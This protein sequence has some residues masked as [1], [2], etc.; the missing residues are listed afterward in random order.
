[1]AVKGKSKSKLSAAQDDGA[2]K[3]VAQKM[4]DSAQQ[5]WLAGLGAF[6]KAQDE[7]SK[8]FDNLVSEGNALEKATRKLTTKSVDDVRD[9]VENTVSQVR[10]RASDSWDRL[11]EVFENRVARALSKLGIPSRDDLQ[12][13]NR[14]IDELTR[15]VKTMKKSG[16]VEAATK[17]ADSAVKSA[18]S[19]ATKAMSSAKKTVASAKKSVDSV[20][21]T[22][23]ASASKAKTAATKAVSAAKESI[24]NATESK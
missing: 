15:N 19:T 6:S 20:K 13:L 1:M 17:A 7:G 12:E 24:E 9:V 3:N 5:I 22:V 23:K 2:L 21:K 11:E 16:P 10:Q 4:L 14:R 18:Q 8:W